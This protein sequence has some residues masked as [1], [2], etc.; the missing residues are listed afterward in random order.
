MMSSI[1]L[2][3]FISVGVFGMI[4]AA[5]FCDIHW[6]PRKRLAML[7]GMAVI[8]IFQGIFY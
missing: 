1:H 2:L 3:S 8:L 7:G 5:A 6:T 4:L